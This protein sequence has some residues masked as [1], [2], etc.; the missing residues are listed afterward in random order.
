M[1]TVK[2][3]TLY[4]LVIINLI[5]LGAHIYFIYGA[6]LFRSGSFPVAGLDEASQA[7]VRDLENSIQQGKKPILSLFLWPYAISLVVEIVLWLLVY[8]RSTKAF[9]IVLVFAVLFILLRLFLMYLSYG[10]GHWL[11]FDA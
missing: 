2:K 11:T 4:T 7:A 3:K 6:G 5:I 9:N 10:Y 1:M 8:K